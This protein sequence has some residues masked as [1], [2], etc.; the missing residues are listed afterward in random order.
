MN[1]EVLNQITNIINNAL[2][3]KHGPYYAGLMAITGFFLGYILIENKYGISDGE[4]S[5]QPQ[6][7]ESKQEI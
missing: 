7:I 2:N 4:Y 1:N 5:I 6:E 3:S